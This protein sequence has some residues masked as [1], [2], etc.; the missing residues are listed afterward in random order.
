VNIAFVEGSDLRADRGLPSIA[1]PALPRGLP[2]LFSGDRSASPACIVSDEPGRKTEGVNFGSQDYLSL[3]RRPKIRLAAYDAIE[4]CCVHSA[5]SS[6]FNRQ[7]HVFDRA[8][9]ENI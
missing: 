9:T 7:H 3:A 6:A 4:R 8:R 2:A 1:E 5:G